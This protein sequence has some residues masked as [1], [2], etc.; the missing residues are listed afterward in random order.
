MTGVRGGAQGGAGVRGWGAYLGEPALLR[1]CRLLAVRDVHR[2]V[3]HVAGAG[4]ETV[5]AF[6]HAREHASTGF[7]V[8]LGRSLR[9][10]NEP[11]QWPRRMEVTQ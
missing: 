7:R 10:F 5:L 6:L 11:A 3:L 8:P 1:A 2:R 9:P 4:P